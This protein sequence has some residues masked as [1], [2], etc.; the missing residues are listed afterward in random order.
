[1]TG[2]ELMRGDTVDSNSAKIAC[3]LAETGVVVQE[4][5]TVGDDRQRLSAAIARLA[6]DHAV[7]IVNGGLG[8]TSDDLTAEVIA[9]LAGIALVEHA[10]ARTHVED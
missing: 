10:K 3:A 2:D 5:A 6:E 1:M 4:K 9:Q 7:L 8:P